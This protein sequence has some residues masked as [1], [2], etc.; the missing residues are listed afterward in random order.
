MSNSLFITGSS[1]FVAGHLLRRLPLERYDKVYCLSRGESDVVRS[2]AQAGQ[3]EFIAA[4]LLDVEAYASRLASA[5]IVVHLAAVTGKAKRQ[6]Y[7][8]VNAAGTDALVKKCREVGIPRLLHTST[9]AV[10]YRNIK[11]YYYA[12]SKRQAEAIVRDSGLRYTI[13]RPTIVLGRDAANWPPLRKM[14]T[15]AI[16]TL[17]GN[18]RALVQPIHVDD[19]V[20]AMAHLI[21]HEKFDNETIDL[22]GPDAVSIE[23]FLCRIR[24]RVLGD[25][26]PR[27]VHLPLGLMRGS[28]GFIERYLFSGLPVTAGQL[29]VFG[30]DGPAE[31]HPALRDVRSGMM[32]LDALLD[33]L[34]DEHP[35]GS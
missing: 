9:I 2:L 29:S 8:D 3:V 12:Q 19:L 21:E 30:N 17:P 14:A 4:D 23:N 6:T 32:S 18:G 1:G 5:D 13:V 15:G 22:G 7:F 26:T 35:D 16:L 33:Q 25:Q 27:V 24:Q 34:T 28:L 11:Y 20:D 31:E 10:K